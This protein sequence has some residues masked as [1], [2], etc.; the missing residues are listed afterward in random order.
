MQQY[1]FGLR[2]ATT[3]PL[4]GALP[5]APGDV[6][7]PDFRIMLE[8]AA[9]VAEPHGF[10]VDGGTVTYTTGQ[11][12][13][14]CT[15]DA[16]CVTP[17][18]DA[19]LDEL[20]QLLIANALPAS[21]WL[22]GMFLLHAAVVRLPGADRAVAIAGVS[23]SGKSTIAAALVDEGAEL[24]ADDCAAL[25]V[26]DQ[27]IEA[28]GLAGGL[29]LRSAD[30]N[31]RAFRTV[32]PGG[33]RG[34]SALDAIFILDSGLDGNAAVPFDP[35]RA[36]EQLLAHR[37]RPQVPALLQQQGR[38]LHQVIAIAKTL[39]VLALPQGHARADVGRTIIKTISPD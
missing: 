30:G 5:L 11:G 12:S 10:A 4:P 16:I 27:S 7:A 29:F 14:D 35:I 32:T 8:G 28:A 22:R 37:H 23:G 17:A 21:L 9:D 39:P 13:Y 25:S 38:V 33:A 2:L 26:G 15:V 6:A 3:L 34:V 31:S 19:P 36:T 1:G 18:P 20:S 24:I